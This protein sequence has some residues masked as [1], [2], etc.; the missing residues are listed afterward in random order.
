MVPPEEKEATPQAGGPG[1]APAVPAPPGP[2]P[3]GPA[4]GAQDS[5]PG[6]QQF[7]DDAYPEDGGGYASAEPPG[8]A[9]AIA[10][11]SPPEDQTIGS[12]PPA[13]PSGGGGGGGDGHDEDDEGMVRMSFFDHLAELRTRLL[14]SVGGLALAFALPLLYANGLWNIASRPAVY[15]LEQLKVNPPELTQIKPMETFNVIWL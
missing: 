13:P 9:L 15:A 6:T 1:Q 10:P 12:Q 4:D 5:H 7:Y 11:P 14:Y 3:S 2:A 8:T